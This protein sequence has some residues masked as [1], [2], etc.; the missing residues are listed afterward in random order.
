M[1]QP[2]GIGQFEQFVLTAILALGEDAYGV[3][4]HAKVQTLVQP[5]TVVLGAVYSTLDRLEDKGLISSWLSDPTPERGGRSKRY[6]RLQPMGERALRDS[7]LSARRVCVE[8]ERIWGAHAWT[9]G[10]RWKPVRQS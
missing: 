7:V 2:A 3:T 5:K 10:T 1:P 9:P 4:I 6:Y 8:V